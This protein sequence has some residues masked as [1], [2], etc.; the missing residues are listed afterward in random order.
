MRLGDDEK[1]LR[2][3][4]QESHKVGR[5]AESG[6][7]R[8]QTITGHAIE[9]GRPW[10]VCCRRVVNGRCIGEAVAFGSSGPCAWP[11]HRM[12]SRPQ[13]RLQ[14]A[15]SLAATIDVSRRDVTSRAGAVHRPGAG[16]VY[17]GRNHDLVMFVGC[18]AG[19]TRPTRS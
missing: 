12:G 15:L 6:Q 8:R 16:E 10:L 5:A 11:A 4:T 3:Q 18:W 9:V 7:R 13:R 17:T 2:R 1:D 14:S 19:A